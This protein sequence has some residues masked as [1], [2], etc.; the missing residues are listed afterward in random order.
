M[1]VLVPPASP[2]QTPPAANTSSA[3]TYTQE[4][5]RRWL[6]NIF[7]ELLLVKAH[8]CTFPMDGEGKN[9]PTPPPLPFLSPPFSLSQDFYLFLEAPHL[10]RTLPTV[11]SS[12]C[13]TAGCVVPLP[14]TCNVLAELI[15]RHL[16]LLQRSASVT[17]ALTPSLFHAV[18]AYTLSVSSLRLHRVPPSP[19]MPSAPSC[20]V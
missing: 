8:G 7:E 3:N 13:C 15:P 10:C 17:V 12:P 5:L 6:K 18:C 14:E 11:C 4:Q 9:S 16:H 20:H 1:S 19:T 2:L